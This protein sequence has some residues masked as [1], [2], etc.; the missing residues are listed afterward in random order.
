MPGSRRLSAVA[1]AWR[2]LSWPH[3]L[4]V[5][6][7]YHDPQDALSRQTADYAF[8]RMDFRALIIGGVAARACQESPIFRAKN[9]V[10][11]LQQFAACRIGKA[12]ARPHS[13][14]RPAGFGS[15]IG[16]VGINVEWPGRAFHDLARDHHFL[17][18]FEAGQIEHGV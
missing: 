2:R 3:V 13:G 15:A 4:I 16:S 5:V 14:T 7:V 17:D 1:L 10:T 9:R 6:H 11:K 8:L 12:E 18:P